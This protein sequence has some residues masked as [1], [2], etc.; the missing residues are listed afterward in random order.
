MAPPD[1]ARHRSAGLVALGL[2]SWLAATAAAQTPPVAPWLQDAFP[3][4]YSAPAAPAL[5]IR[6]ATILDGAGQRLDNA[7]IRLADGRVVA[8]GHGLEN[9]GGDTEIDAR[10]RWLTPGI[11]DVHSHD[12]TVAQPRTTIDQE[13]S[14]VSELSDPN[15]A[16]TLIETAVNPQDP[17]FS[18]ALRSGVTTLQILPGSS[19]VFGGRSVVVHPIRATTVAAM[20]LPSAPPGFKMACGENPKAHG[21]ESRRGPTSRQG[22]IAYIRRTLA[23]AR[24]YLREWNRFASAADD[25]E[26]SERRSD[27]RERHRGPPPQRDGPRADARRAVLAGIVNGDFRLNVHCYRADDMAVMLSVAREFGF[28]I[29]AFH[30]AAEAYKIPELLREHGACAAVW[31]DWWGFKMEAQDAIRA[32]AALLDEAGVCV[33]MHS[34]SAS[35]GQR[36]PLEAA[37]AAGA[38]RAAGIVIPPERMIRW[39]TSNPAR[40][41][42]LD[43]RIGTLAPGFEADI[44]LWSGDPFSVYTRADLVIIGGAIAYDRANPPADPPSDF[45]LGREAVIDR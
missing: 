34:D 30:H 33:A 8:V 10:G 22:E 40:I 14:D 43:R 6:N 16:D 17:A 13:A 9:G 4:T 32:N 25:A 21:A 28:R 5:L 29:T 31:G 39:V 18:R 11:I 27:R 2:A 19:P 35:S 7:D 36:L 1:M 44:V 41:L 26:A 37:K 12:G 3:S 20:E 23:D 15:V 24:D 38:A 45:E 42:G